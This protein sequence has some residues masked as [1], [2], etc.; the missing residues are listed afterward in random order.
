M[1][2]RT[3][4]LTTDSDTPYS[5]LT[6]MIVPVAIGV[7]VL[8]FSIGIGLGCLCGVNYSRCKMRCRSN[9]PAPQDDNVSSNV[10]GPIYEEVVLEDTTASINLSKNLAY[11]CTKKL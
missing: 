7:S 3:N 1:T 5:M 4:E 11:E 8:F 2:S 6:N 9:N 10:P